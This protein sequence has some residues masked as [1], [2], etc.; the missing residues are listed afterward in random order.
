MKKKNITT[1]IA[2]LDGSPVSSIFEIGKIK[3]V[4]HISDLLPQPQPQL[5][6]QDNLILDINQW[7]VERY[8]EYCKTP[9]TDTPK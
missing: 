1:G 9:D 4:K 8:P 3:R 2:D 7:L 6:G 5:Q